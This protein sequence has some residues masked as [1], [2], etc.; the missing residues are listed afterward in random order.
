MVDLLLE[1]NL[2][3]PLARE[4]SRSLV[5]IILFLYH[6]TLLIFLYLATEQ[7]RDSRFKPDAN[8]GDPLLFR[9]RLVNCGVVLL[10]RCLGYTR[11]EEEAQN[12]DLYGTRW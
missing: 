3:D 8:N 6:R 7:Q 4:M 1:F 2:C 9:D 12:R 5:A 11:A 10:E